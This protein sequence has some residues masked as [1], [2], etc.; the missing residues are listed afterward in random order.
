MVFKRKAV[1][2]KIQS[3][4]LAQSY[5]FTDI[6][7]RE[8]DPGNFLNFN[9]LDLIAVIILQNAFLCHLVGLVDILGHVGKFFNFWSTNEITA[10]FRKSPPFL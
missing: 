9:P 5:F 4:I 2:S 7:S 10:C 3:F 6:Q 1:S 8:K